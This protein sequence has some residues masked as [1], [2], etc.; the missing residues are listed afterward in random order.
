MMTGLFS[1]S[2]NRKIAFKIVYRTFS[3]SKIKKIAVEIQ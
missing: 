3:T 2:K 1:T